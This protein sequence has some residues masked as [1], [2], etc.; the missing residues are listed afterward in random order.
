MLKGR[1]KKSACTMIMELFRFV[2]I[3][4]YVYTSMFSC[5]P[6]K[7]QRKAFV[8]LLPCLSNLT[9][10]CTKRVCENT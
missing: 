10:L 6:F 7:H 9:E 3:N 5:F 2:R 4:I 1:V 8:F